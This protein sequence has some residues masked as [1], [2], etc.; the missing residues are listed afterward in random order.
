MVPQ[1]LNHL[2]RA[3]AI[4]LEDIENGLSDAFRRLLVGL[5]GDFYG[6]DERVKKLDTQM[7]KAAKEDSVARRLLQLRGVGP[8]IATALSAALGDG[9]A[10]RNGRVLP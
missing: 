6:L 3:I 1:C 8:V 7:E 2:R 4:W 10:F 9:L 5:Q